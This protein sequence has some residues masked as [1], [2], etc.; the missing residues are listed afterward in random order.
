VGLTILVGPKLKEIDL[1]FNPIYSLGDYILEIANNHIYQIIAR[2]QISIFDLGLASLIFTLLLV[3]Y[4]LFKLIM[5]ANKNSR[6]DYHHSHGP[7]LLLFRAAIK[8]ASKRLKK[9]PGKPSIN[10]HPSLRITEQLE[11]GNIFVSGQQGGGKS[12]VIKPLA[13]QVYDT[14]CHS[15]THDEKGEYQGNLKKQNIVCLELKENA[16]YIW[17]I[18]S[19]VQNSNDASLVA[20]AMLED[21]NDNEQFFVDS[22]RQVLKGVIISLQNSND[23]WS[24]KELDCSLFSDSKQLK[25]LLEDA[26]P[27]AS[28]LI[29][30][31]SKTTQSIRSVLSSRLFWLSEMAELQKSAKNLWSISSMMMTSNN[32]KHVF[33]RPNYSNPELSRAVCNTLITLLIERWL[34][35]D[36]S[37]QHKLWM[38]LDEL[39]NIPKNQSLIRWLTLSRSKGGRTIAGTQSL[40]QLFESYGQNITETILALFRTVIVMRL[41]A[42][43]PSAQKA[44]ELLGQ[45]RVVTFNQNLSDCDKLSISTQFHDRAVVTKEDIV[46]LPSSDRKGVVGFLHIGGLKNVYKLKWGFIKTSKPIITKSIPSPGKPIITPML[47]IQPTNRLNKRH[48]PLIKKFEDVKL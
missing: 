43:G 42:S 1:V 12:T 35:R 24:W 15:F 37:N 27:P 39:G 17:E 32:K 10:I 40:S 38:I 14:D 22:A 4:F 47:E 18:S 23:Y 31:D 16:E 30:P 19:D 26:Y 9:E 2:T 29:E 48:K 7:K 21:G 20:K 3:G 8:D 45:Q 28:T 36:D 34:V 44:S 46:N 6:P 13:K 11:Q 33:F 25:Q 41:G 5:K